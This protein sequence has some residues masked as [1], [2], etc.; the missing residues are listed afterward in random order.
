MQ[1]CGKEE[2]AIRRSELFEFC[3][4][5]TWKY[6]SGT[7]DAA[8]SP[9]DK[10]VVLLRRCSQ[11]EHKPSSCS[12]RSCRPS[13]LR[14]TPDPQCPVTC[15]PEQPEQF[16]SCPAVSN[17]ARFSKQGFVYLQRVQKTRGGC[18]RLPTEEADQP[19]LP[20]ER[21]V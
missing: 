12:S 20:V 4:T 16:L 8:Q 18:W 11:A 3:Y 10:D 19:R 2:R 15:S 14:L 9:V 13:W 6:P 5:Q 21:K 1:E 7:Q 17:P